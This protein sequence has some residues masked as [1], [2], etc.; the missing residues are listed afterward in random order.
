MREQIYKAWRARKVLSRI[1][2]DV[3]GAYNGVCKER[4]LERMRSRGIPDQVVRWVD[5]FCS[6][7]TATIVVNGHTAE[8]CSLSQAGLPQGSPLSPVLFLFVNADLVQRRI[9]A[10]GGSI[11]FIDDYS[12]W[13]TGPTAEANQAGIQSIIDDALKWEGPQWRDI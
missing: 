10:V 5:A 4:L 3:K 9:K 12:A 2:F 1:S 6:A 13:V 7:R 11:T 8:L